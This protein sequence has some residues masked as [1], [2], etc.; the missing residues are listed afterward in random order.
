MHDLHRSWHAGAD[1]R[2]SNRG[3]KIVEFPTMKR[4]R[5][6]YHS[7]EYA[8]ALTVSQKALKRRLIFVEGVQRAITPRVGGAE[9]AH[10]AGSSLAARR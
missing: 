1:T 4:A 9:A 2:V 8:K 3:E 7:A 6:W 10:I 5:E